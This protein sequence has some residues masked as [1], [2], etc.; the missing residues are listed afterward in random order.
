MKQEKKLWVSPK[1]EKHSRETVEIL[2]SGT[3]GEGSMELS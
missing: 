3:L 1:L 2:K